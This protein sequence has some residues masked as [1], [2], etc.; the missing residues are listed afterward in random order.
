MSDDVAAEPL[1]I[2][3][4]TYHEI[5]LNGGSFARAMLWKLRWSSLGKFLGLMTLGYRVEAVAILGR[6]IIAPRGPIGLGKDTLDHSTP[7]IRGIFTLLADTNNYP[8]LIHCTQGKDR[9]GLVVTLLLLLLDVPCS[10]ISPDY[11]ASENELK[12]ERESRMEELSRH[13]MGE[14]FATCPAGFVQEIADH[15]QHVY[16]GV[17]HY[18]THIGVDE[19]TQNHVKENV[20]EN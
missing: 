11:M 19:N 2:P 20:L 14:E 3:G 1:K 12:S 15:L 7:E 17:N 5:N 9:T 8:V 6:E 4:V 10:A 16:G 13:G 18:L